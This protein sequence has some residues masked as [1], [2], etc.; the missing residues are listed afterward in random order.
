MGYLNEK[1]VYLAGSILSCKDDG[2]GW[3]VAITPKLQTYGLEIL[4]PTR[5][6]TEECCEVTDDKKKFKDIAKTKDFAKLKEEFMPVA[7]W[8]LRS[9]DKSDFVIVSYDFSVPTFGTV[10]EITTA[11]QQQKP[12]LFHFDESQLDLFNPWT[13]VRVNPKHIFTEW[14]DLFNHLD[15]IDK[16]NFN[17]K[18]WTL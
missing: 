17:R 18:Y 16:G 8:D 3:R 14:D 10:D 13:I 12:I 2:I 11:S 9:V 15:E 6:T 4:D 1:S 5:K 7:R